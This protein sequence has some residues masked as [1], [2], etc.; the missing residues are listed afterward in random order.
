MTN[1]F[2]SEGDPRNTSVFNVFM[3]MNAAEPIERNPYPNAKLLMPGF[4]SLLVWQSRYPGFPPE[5]PERPISANEFMPICSTLSGI[6]IEEI[7]H[8]PENE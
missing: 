3:L 6:V 2:K 8:W 1:A 4:L 5:A 7:P